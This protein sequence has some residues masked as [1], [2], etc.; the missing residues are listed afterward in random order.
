MK[1]KHEIPEESTSNQSAFP[2][3][4]AHGYTSEFSQ[5]MTLRDYFAAKSMN[6]AMSDFSH[7]SAMMHDYTNE[8]NE[9]ESPRE[10][11]ARVFY[12]M[13]DAMLKQRNQ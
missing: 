2:I 13:A 10:Y 12:Q 3:D 5:G 6:G 11:A 4:A 8:R 1:S 9:G 7:W